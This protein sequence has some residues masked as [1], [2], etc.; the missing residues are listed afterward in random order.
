M[1]ICLNLSLWNHLPFKIEHAVK[2][3]DTLVAISG[4]AINITFMSHEHDVSNHRQLDW[5]L[6]SVCGLIHYNDV[7]MSTMAYQMTGV[8]SVYSTLYTGANHRKQ[9]SSASLAFVRGIHR[10]PVNVSIWWRH[11]EQRKYQSSTINQYY[12]NQ[13]LLWWESTGHSTVD[14]WIPITMFPW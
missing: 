8:S 3:H 13:S 2:P 10:W 7:I 14:R 5:L 4:G 12:L 1:R 11:H 9:Q 6:N